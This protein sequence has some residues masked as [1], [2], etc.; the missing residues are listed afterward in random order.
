MGNSVG[1]FSLRRKGT[2]GLARPV[3]HLPPAAHP[4]PPALFTPPA[5]RQSFGFSRTVLSHRLT[6]MKFSIGT[7]DEPAR[8]Q[9]DP[10]SGPNAIPVPRGD[11]CSS[12]CACF[13]IEPPCARRR[14]IRGAT[15]VA[16]PGRRSLA[17]DLPRAF[18]PRS[19]LAG[20]NPESI[21]SLR[22][23]PSAKH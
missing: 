13:R 19:V 3:G 7:G 9:A 20:A 17:A 15:D 8:I 6:W 21:W 23:A 12:T 2:R 4:D 16:E 5:F 22:E 1:C 14:Q 10:V 18:E 11:R